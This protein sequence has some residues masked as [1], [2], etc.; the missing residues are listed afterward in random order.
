MTARLVRGCTPAP[1]SGRLVKPP[2]TT[3]DEESSRQLRCSNRLRLRRFVRFQGSGVFHHPTL[4]ELSWVFAERRQPLELLGR[5]VRSRLPRVEVRIVR[6]HA[7]LRRIRPNAR[8]VD[9]GLNAFPAPGPTRRTRRPASS[10]RVVGVFVHYLEAE[11]QVEADR[12]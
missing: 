10:T 11:P 8:S 3:H 7:H 1:I 9:L 5:R 6:R 2:I 12:R 4:P